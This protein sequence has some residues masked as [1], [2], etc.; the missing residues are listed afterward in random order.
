[1]TRTPTYH[2]SPAFD[3]GLEKVRFEFHNIDHGIDPAVVHGNYAGEPFLQSLQIQ[4]IF[5]RK[6]A[7]ALD[8]LHHGGIR[9]CL[10]A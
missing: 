9:R 6:F 3:H 5:G 1:M 8:L 2:F 4:S 10:Q 7:H